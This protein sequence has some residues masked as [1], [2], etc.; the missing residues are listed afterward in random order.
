VFQL[1]GM[2]RRFEQLA[3][4]MNEYSVQRQ[5]SPE[6]SNCEMEMSDLAAKLDKG[7]IAL[8]RLI[9]SFLLIICLV[10]AILFLYGIV[11]VL[12]R[13][14]ASGFGY[15]MVAFCGLFGF[16]YSVVS[17]IMV[18]DDDP[19]SEVL[20]NVIVFLSAIFLM[21]VGLKVYSDEFGGITF[22]NWAIIVLPT[23][24]Y[25]FAYVIGV[26]IGR[27]LVDEFDLGQYY[28]NRLNMIRR[29]IS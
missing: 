15:L 16:A 5:W 28:D 20:L 1:M 11:V 27:V 23:I 29:R 3:Q 7:F 10:I 25:V 22:S 26:W 4:K 17:F 6:Q 8:A 2:A 19:G 13:G 21:G 12:S 18:I 24:V 9:S 14:S